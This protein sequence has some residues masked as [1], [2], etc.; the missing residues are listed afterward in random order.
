MIVIAPTQTKSILTSLLNLRRAVAPFPIS[1]FFGEYHVAGPVASHQLDYPVQV[2]FHL[3]EALVVVA[4]NPSAR[5]PQLVSLEHF[6]R[7]IR[8]GRFREV[9]PVAAALDHFESGII[10]LGRRDAPKA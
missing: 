5:F 4:E 1:S 6:R 7:V 3:V 9:T 8:A 10:F 2:S